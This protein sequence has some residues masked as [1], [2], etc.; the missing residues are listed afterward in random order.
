MDTDSIPFLLIVWILI[1]LGPT[2]ASAEKNAF[3]QASFAP[4][5]LNSSLGRL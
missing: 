4:F 3:N 5:V 1:V 2:Y